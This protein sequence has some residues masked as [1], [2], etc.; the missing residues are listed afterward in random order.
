MDSEDIVFLSAIELGHRIASKQISL[1]GATGAWHRCVQCIEPKLN[2]CIKVT[3]DH[4]KRICAPVSLPLTY[5]AR[6]IASALIHIGE[7]EE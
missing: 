6:A 7:V 1:V 3:A 5:C 2:A 4:A